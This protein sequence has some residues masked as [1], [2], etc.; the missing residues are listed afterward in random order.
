[1]NNEIELSRN[2]VLSLRGSHFSHLLWPEPHAEDRH[3]W[4]RYLKYVIVIGDRGDGN[5]FGQG[6]YRWHETEV[7]RVVVRSKARNLD[8]GLQLNCLRRD[9]KVLADSTPLRILLTIISVSPKAWANTKSRSRTRITRS[10]VSR[11]S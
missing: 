9:L 1:M 5:L 3:Y 4:R 11:H 7:K 8:G 2:E 6:K 10:V